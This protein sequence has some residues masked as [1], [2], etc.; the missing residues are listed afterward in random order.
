MMAI[1]IKAKVETSGTIFLT[2]IPVMEALE[3]RMD[4]VALVTV[5][6]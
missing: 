3:K 4:Q 2:T 5:A 6:T 1:T